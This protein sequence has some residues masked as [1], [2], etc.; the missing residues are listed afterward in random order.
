[1]QDYKKTTAL[2]KLTPRLFCQNNR[3]TPHKAVLA[4]LII[5]PI[6]LVRTKDPATKRY[7]VIFISVKRPIK[8]PIIAV[9]T[10]EKN[11]GTP[12]AKI[13]VSPRIRRPITPENQIRKC[14]NA[15]NPF[16]CER[17]SMSPRWYMF[18]LFV[19]LS[20]RKRIKDPFAFFKNQ[21]LF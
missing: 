18:Y 5:R 2:I 15:L 1:M 6:R 19:I 21:L 16:F 12:A 13:R 9:T 7:H 10:R 11:Q 14:I 20:E 8:I 17:I 3:S 4:S